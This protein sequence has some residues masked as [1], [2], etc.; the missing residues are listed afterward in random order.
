MIVLDKHTGKLRG[1]GRFRHRAR[2]HPRPVEF[3][4]AWARSAGGT[5]FFFGAGNGV[6][7]AF[8]P[9]ATSG[10]RPKS[11]RLLKNVWR[12]HGHPLAQTAGHVPPDHQHDSHVRTR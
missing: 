3:A 12:F 2:H 1:P 7:Y 4:G 9:L 5:L 6:L 11:R 8:E 10:G